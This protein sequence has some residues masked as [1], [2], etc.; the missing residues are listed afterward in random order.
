MS[1]GDMEMKCWNCLVQRTIHIEYISFNPGDNYKVVI[2]RCTW[3]K[4]INV[5]QEL[6]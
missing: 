1:C 2:G 4:K 3:C 6:V 5:K